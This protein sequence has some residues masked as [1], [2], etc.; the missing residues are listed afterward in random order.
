MVIFAMAAG[1]FLVGSVVSW[2]AL[3]PDATLAF[4]LLIVAGIIAHKPP[5]SSR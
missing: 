3:F 1:G 5:I 4:T 2:G